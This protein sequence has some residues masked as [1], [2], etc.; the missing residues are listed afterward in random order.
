[1]FCIAN[2]LS[3]A[4][5]QEVRTLLADQSFQSGSR[6]AGWAATLVK[7]NEQLDPTARHYREAAATGRRRR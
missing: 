1:M 3:A 6:T 5:L 2:V 7:N 4:Q